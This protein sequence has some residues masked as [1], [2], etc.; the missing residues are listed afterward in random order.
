MIHVYVDGQEGTTGLKIHERLAGRADIALLTID[1]A[2]RKDP[3]ERAKLINQADI[4]FLCLPDAAAR[5]AV[6]LCDNP[7]TRIIDAS[8]AHRVNP[9]WAYG[10]PELSPAHRAR[11]ASAK[12][13][14][15]P[16]CYASGFIA[17]IYPLIRAGALS[18]D[19]Q[20]TCNALSGYSGGGK[21]MIAQYEQAPLADALKGPR[22]YGLTLTHKHLPEMRILS[23][24]TRAPIFIPTVAAYYQG[25]TVSIPLFAEQL[26]GRSARQV[27]QLL[28]DHYAGQRFIQVLP[29]GGEG[30]LDGAFLDPQ[31][32]NGTNRMELFVFGDDD[33][34]VLTARLDN[35]GKGASGA[36][37]QCMNIMLGIDEGEGLAG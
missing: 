10:I 18:P 28:A 13:V 12:R 31:G 5:E 6:A 17:Q 9:D 22:A 20:V 4:V 34:T 16:G 14:A 25:M 1:P 24:L 8:T 23:G 35:L 2:L 15:A 21:K 30:R 33:R 3:A 26:G 36:A 32:C 29:F 37:V 27:H 19:A 11:I 7:N